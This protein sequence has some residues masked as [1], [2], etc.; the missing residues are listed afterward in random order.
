LISSPLAEKNQGPSRPNHGA[1]SW[2]GIAHEKSMRREEEM[3]GKRIGV[4]KH[5]VSVA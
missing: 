3:I 2:P 1:A 4:E 5:L